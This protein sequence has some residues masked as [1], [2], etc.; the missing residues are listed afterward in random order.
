MV[1]IAGSI[2][3][4]QVLEALRDARPVFHSEAD[5]Q[6]ALGQA[7]HEIDRS[8]AIRLEVGISRQLTDVRGR[9]QYLD[10][11]CTS[12]A[13]RTAIE[14]KYM[15]NRWLGS[16]G[17]E[18]FDLRDHAATDLGRRGFVFDIHRLESFLAA[19][20][21]IDNGIAIMLS[22]YRALWAE[23]KVPPQTRDRMFRIHDGGLL[24]GTLKWGDNDVEASRREL[25]GSYKLAWHPW[26]EVGGANGEFKVLV[27]EVGRPPSI[28]QA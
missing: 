7:I 20:S 26:A 27:V 9:R 12:P 4:S 15:T 25:S 6:L 14:L 23:P 22:N 16:A 18:A 21:S 19:D 5:F 11:M 1:M 10:V 24:A 8:V 13:G 17:D 3:L 2:K 28:E